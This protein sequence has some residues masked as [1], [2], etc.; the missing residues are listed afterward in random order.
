MR[1]EKR[2][3]RAALYGGVGAAVGTGLGTTLLISVGPIA[4]AG[5]AVLGAVAGLFVGLSW[6]QRGD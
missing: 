5:G 4:V 3:E 2:W 1:D 6:N